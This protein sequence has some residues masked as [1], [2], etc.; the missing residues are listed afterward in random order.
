MVTP[1]VVYRKLTAFNPGW[2]VTDGLPSWIAIPGV[3]DSPING[4]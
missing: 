3:G 1:F 2:K 4:E